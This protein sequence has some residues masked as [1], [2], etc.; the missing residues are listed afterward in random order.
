[1]DGQWPEALKKPKE[2]GIG[3][4]GILVCQRQGEREQTKTLA[5]QPASAI[6]LP[7]NAPF[8]RPGMGNGAPESSSTKASSA[9]SLY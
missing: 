3:V 9:F 8:I 7:P 6:L 2:H 1:M 4:S 5:Q